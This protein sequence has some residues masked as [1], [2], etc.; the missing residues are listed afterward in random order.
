[1]NISGCKCLQ[2][3]PARPPPFPSSGGW[4][5]RAGVVAPRSIQAGLRFPPGFPPWARKRARSGWACRPSMTRSRGVLRSGPCMSLR[6]QASCS[7]APPSGSGSPSRP[8]RA[9]AGGREVLCIATDYAALAAGTPYGLGLDRLG[10]AMDRLLILRVAHPRDALWAFEEA[11]KCPAL[12]AVLAE[13]PEEGAAADLTATRRLLLAAQTGGGL[14]LLLRH[15][16]CPLGSGAMT[17][18]Q[19]AAALEPSPTASA[20][21]AA[22]ASIS[23]CSGTGAA[24]AAAGSW[25]G[26]TMSASSSRRRYLSVWLRRLATDRIARRS[27]A[28]PEPRLWSLPCRSRMPCS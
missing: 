9:R 12:A 22:P 5:Q 16:P 13:L 28:S 6:P 18:W 23:P 14:G 1:M 27:A 11:L 2:P 21:S 10:L 17:R 20:G 19:V 8:G 25:V 4:S 24:A 26:T 3:L 15:R 7:S